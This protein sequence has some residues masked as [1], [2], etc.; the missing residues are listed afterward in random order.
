MNI[1]PSRRY[2]DHE[3]YAVTAATTGTTEVAA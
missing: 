2:R 3:E 1:E